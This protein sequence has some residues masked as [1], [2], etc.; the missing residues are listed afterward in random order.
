MSVTRIAVGML[1]VALLVAQP[2]AAQSRQQDRR[3]YQLDPKEVKALVGRI[4]KNSNRFKKSVDKGLDNSRLN[5]TRTETEINTYVRE[6][7]NAADR[8]KK[9]T[10]KGD[11]S[12][13]DAREVLQH[14]DRI[15]RYMDRYN[16]G[17]RA[18]SDWDTLRGD[19]DDLARIT[20]IS[21]QWGGR[22]RPGWTSRDRDPN[23][24][25]GS[26]TRWPGRGG[27]PGYSPEAIRGVVARIETGANRFRK[28]LDSALDDSRL[29]QTP[30]EREINQYVRDFENATD[31]L[32]ER[33]QRG[34]QVDVVTRDVLRRGDNIDRFMQSHRLNDRSQRD[35]TALRNDLD[36]LARA[37][38]VSWRWSR[39]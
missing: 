13:N 6:F 30:T 2:G 14:A 26:D 1:S 25:Y 39:R 17:R 34:E 27:Y 36:E 23:Y 33:V 29:N 11:I 9:H 28:S 32:K 24:P 10:H 22:G 4:E 21:W 3:Y 5:Q 35:W 8:L 18:E 15:D 16:L 37:T 20:R 19:L 31:Q 12:E 7:E 38:Q